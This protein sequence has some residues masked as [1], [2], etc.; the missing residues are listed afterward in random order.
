[1][2]TGVFVL[3]WVFILLAAA[4]DSYFAYSYSAILEQ[5]EMNPF[6]RWAAN[7]VGLA[8]VF[9]FKAMGLGFS[10]GLAIYCRSARV[11]LGELVTWTGGACYLFLVL[12]YAVHLRW[13]I[14]GEIH[15]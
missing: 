2:R 3:V 11:E 13:S 1:M 4:Y 8:A 14:F 12:Y 6:I 5:W 7:M 10:I 9:G 15:P